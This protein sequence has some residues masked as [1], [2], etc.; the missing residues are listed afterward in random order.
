VIKLKTYRGKLNNWQT[1]TIKVPGD[2]ISQYFPD[3]IGKDLIIVT[4]YITDDPTNKRNDYDHCRTSFVLTIDRDRGILTTLNSTYELGK[5]GG[6]V[7]GGD[8]GNAI[9]GLFY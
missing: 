7:L 4:G 8:M 5:E 3:L 9:L 2:Q 6:D 1:H